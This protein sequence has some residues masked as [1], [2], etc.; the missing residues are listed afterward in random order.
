MCI[1]YALP[2]SIRMLL[3][4]C[5][6]MLLVCNCMLPVCNSYVPVC[7]RMLLVCIR[8]LLVCIRMLLVCSCM[9]S[10]CNLYV[11]VC[12]RMLTVC[13]SYIL[14]CTLM[15][16]CVTPYVTRIFTRMYPCGVLFN[17]DSKR[18]VV[19]P[20]IDIF[21]SLL[22]RLGLSDLRRVLL[23]VSVLFVTFRNMVPAWGGLLTVESRGANIIKYLSLLYVIKVKIQGRG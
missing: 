14:V 19:L 7:I 17:R 22:L 4:V 12:I 2:A 16:P 1:S 9:L 23:N 10:V 6:R 13:Y 15:Y 3:E 5:I 11:P 21:F 20:L 18:L 8:M